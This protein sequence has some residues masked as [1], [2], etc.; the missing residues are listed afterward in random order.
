MSRSERFYERKLQRYF[1]EYYGAY[2]YSDEYE[3]AV[4]Y[5]VNPAPNQWKFYIPDLGVVVILTCD[6]SGE[7]DEIRYTRE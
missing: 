6:D 5:Y 2:E 3:D 1:D 4:E 7:V